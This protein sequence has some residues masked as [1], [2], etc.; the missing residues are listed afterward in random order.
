MDGG[1][2]MRGVQKYAENYI[3]KRVERRPCG[4]VKCRYWDN[5]KIYLQKFELDWTELAKERV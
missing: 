1:S 2:S 3:R 4:R 5:I